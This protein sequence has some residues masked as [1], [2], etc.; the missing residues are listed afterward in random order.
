VYDLLGYMTGD[1]LFTHQ[2]PRASREC[3]PALLA[4]HPDLADVKVPDR[5]ENEAAVWLWL[6]AQVDRYGMTR[7]VSPLPAGDHTR[8]DPTAELRMLKPDVKVIV[9]GVPDG[10]P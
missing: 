6:A 9:L 10:A 1:E 3:E 7:E 2:L 4:Q 5:F 8:I